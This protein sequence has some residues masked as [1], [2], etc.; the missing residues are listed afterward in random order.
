MQRSFSFLS[1]WLSIWRET[2]GTF[3][4][5]I[6]VEF[7]RL[8]VPVKGQPPHKGAALCHPL[9]NWA[10]PCDMRWPVGS[11][12]RIKRQFTASPSL[13]CSDPRS[14]YCWAL[15]LGFPEWAPRTGTSWWPHE[16]CGRSRSQNLFFWDHW[17]FEVVCNYSTTESTPA[18]HDGQECFFLGRVIR[19]NNV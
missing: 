1:I 8:S 15:P 19:L 3:T 7:S 14:S 4:R 10:C 16:T 9:S 2:I 11:D 17:D 12:R 18:L 6:L 5:Y 13:C